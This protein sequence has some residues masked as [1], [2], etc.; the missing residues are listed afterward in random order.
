M[1]ILISGAGIAGLSLAARLQ[2]RGLAPIVIERAPHRRAGGYMLSLADPGYDAAERMGIAD[3]LHAAQ[4]VPRRLVY[5]S[6]EGREK[7]VLQGEALRRLVGARQIN[8]MRGDIEAVLYEKARGNVDIRFGASIASLELHEQGARVR[9]EDGDILDVDLVVGADG[10][11]SR[12]RTLAFGPEPDYVRPLGLRIAAFIL[13]RSEFSE[14]A[15]DGTYSL[16]EVGRAMALAAIRGG[17]LVAFFVYR[18]AGARPGDS[19]QQELHRAFAGAEWLVPRTLECLPRASSVYIDD[20][21]QVVMPGWARCRAVLLGDAGYTVSLI[22]GRGASLAM[23]GACTLAD[24]IADAGDPAAAN[25]AA[26]LARYEQWLRPMV[27]QAQAMA[28]RNVNLFTPA[29]RFQLRARD[30][31]LRLAGLPG[32]A[33]LMRR[34]LYREGQRLPPAGA[35][36][37]GDA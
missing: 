20:V 6:P 18:S 11:H 33:H 7:F 36:R 16:T 37:A 22:A 1:K 2:Q 14:L 35:G 31:L 13:D 12:V 8:L 3:E 24:A 25:V 30:V 26:A 34:A 27:E 17:G 5:M 4:Y 23:A 10:L 32:L 15:G 19:T 21:A 9:L 28:R 29:S